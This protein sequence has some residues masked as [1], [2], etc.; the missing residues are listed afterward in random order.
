MLSNHCAS[1]FGLLA[2]LF[3]LLCV[4][5]A[6]HAG[7]QVYLTS[8]CGSGATVS[9]IDGMMFM[10]DGFVP[11]A[12]GT[13]AI[14]ISP[15]GMTGYIAIPAAYG[16]GT[17]KVVDL[18][19]HM[20]ENTF[21]AGNGPAAIAITPDGATGYIANSK[22]GSVTVF[23]TAT[24]AVTATLPVVPGGTCRDA[25]AAPDGSKIY[26][27]CQAT[28]DGVNYQNSLA[29]I[30]TGGQGVLQMITLPGT[31][32]FPSN[33]LLS[34]T[35][36][37]K[38]GYVGGLATSSQAGYASVDLTSGKAS[39]IP[40][41]GTSY[42][43]IVDLLDST[44]LLS[45]RDS[46][47]DVIHAANGQLMTSIPLYASG[48]GGIA[49]L[50]GGMRTA[51]GD[52]DEDMISVIDDTDGHSIATVQAAAAPARVVVSSDEMT[53][54]VGGS[55]STLVS[56]LDAV[57]GKPLGSFEAGTY[58]GAT[59][60]SPDGSTL[61]VVDLGVPGSGSGAGLMAVNAGTL[62]RDSWLP[63]AGASGMALSADG[64]TG[65][66]GSTSG[67]VSVVSTSS[68]AVSQTISLG[69]IAG[70]PSLAITPDGATLGIAYTQ[71]S[72]Q[73]VLSLIS[74]ASGM[75]S[76]TILLGSDA[77]TLT[78]ALAIAGDGK[79]AYVALTHQG[80]VAKVDL[81]QGKLIKTVSTGINPYGLAIRPNG[82]SAYLVSKQGVG[83]LDLTTGAM[84]KTIAVTGL[85]GNVAFTPD[86]TKA[87]VAIQNGAAVV[88]STTSQKVIKQLA[89]S[90]T[91]GVM[92]ATVP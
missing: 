70:E 81:T 79:T 89:V 49:P 77:A 43:L 90:N 34:L 73:N 4:P 15:D 84:T 44:T 5:V 62:Q 11:A 29:V 14:A 71:S 45:V 9:I 17:V 91:A 1:G 59:A 33:N 10:E 78:P 18:M 74:T 21:P 8:C 30:G 38:H 53:T 72:G 23:T 36:D 7:T 85:P 27:V 88:I 87:Y 19:M 86:G 26:V 24:G 40:L 31:L 32:A 3:S 64:S 69:A 41:A 65:Y 68:L 13:T 66:V 2:L 54:V 16:N 67:T 76:Q 83:V 60:M 28:T 51:V 47:M 80:Q 22:D 42:G 55:A 37:G 35:S 61:Y 39:L 25:S 75:I 50:M 46:V 6:S 63:I 82:K 20:V 56:I 57:T 58:P 52:V 48:K 12:G 92:I